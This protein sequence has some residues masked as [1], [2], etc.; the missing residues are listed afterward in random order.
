MKPA[1]AIAAAALGLAVAAGPVHATEPTATAVEYYNASLAHYF[2]TADPAEMQL[3]ESGAEGL[4]WTRTGGE[5]GVFAAAADAP[6]LSA[7]CRFYGAGP[8]SHF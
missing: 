3:V 1:R 7:V 5:F 6:S 4:G 8:N 2:I